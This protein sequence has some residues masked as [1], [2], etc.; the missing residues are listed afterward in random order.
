MLIGMDILRDLHL[1]I[2]YKEKMLFI[3]SAG[4]K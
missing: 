2:A 4:A 3:T 1:F